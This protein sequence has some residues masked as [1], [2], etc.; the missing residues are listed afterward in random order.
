MLSLG[1][2]DWEIAFFP[3][4]IS[5]FPFP[6]LYLCQKMLSCPVHTETISSP[7]SGLGSDTKGVELMQAS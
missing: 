4:L 7:A 2:G 6:P 3:H 1:T 5:F